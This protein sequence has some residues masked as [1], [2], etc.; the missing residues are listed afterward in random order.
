MDSVKVRIHGAPAD[1]PRSFH[2]YPGRPGSGV[3]ELAP[4]TSS[5]SKMKN[6]GEWV[7]PKIDIFAYL[8][9]A[10]KMAFT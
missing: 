10:A 9:T 4:Q 6:Q 3:L 5:F 1:A 8:L 2:R 7:L